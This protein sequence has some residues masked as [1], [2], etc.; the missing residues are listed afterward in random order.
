LVIQKNKWIMTNL[1]T[2]TKNRRSLFLKGALILTF[3][4]ASFLPVKAEQNGME[5]NDSAYYEMPGVNVLMFTNWYNE[6]FSDSKMSG[7][8]IIHHGKR[9]V[10]NGD[11]RLNSTP[12]QWDPIPKFNRKEVDRENNVVKAWLEYPDFEYMIQTEPSGDDIIISVHLDKPIPEKL[13]GMVGFNIEFLP[14]AYFEKTYLMDGKPGLVPHYP[15]GPTKMNESG[16]TE[17]LAIATGHK[18]VLAPEDDTRRIGVESENELMFFDGRNKAQNGW[19]VLRSLIPSGETGR[20]IEW[21]M[22]VSSVDE[23][24]RDPVISFSQVGYHP[25]QTKKAVIELDKNADY[26]SEASLYKLDEN[27]KKVVVHTGNVEQWGFYQRY[28]Y[29]IFDFSD[30][31]ESGIYLVQYGDTESRPLRI[32]E[33]VYDNIWHPTL[34]VFIPVQM[35]HVLVN[36][37][38]RVWHGASHLDDAL[39]APVNHEHFDLYVQG[40]ATDTQYQPG[41]HIP[42]LNVGGW[43]DAGDYDIRTQSQYYTILNLVNAWA[44]FDINRDE[45]LVEQENRYVDLHHPDGKNDILQQIEHGA[46]GLLAQHKAVGHAIPGIIVSDLSQYTH[47]G[48]GLTKTDN[49]I[50]NPALDSLEVDYPYSG[51]F[52]DRWAF[53]SKSTPLNYGSAAALAASSRALKDYAPE[54]AQE[55]LE[56]AIGVWNQEQ[57]KEPDIF[58]VG[59][60]TGGPM[61]LEELRAAT[62]LLIATGNEKYAARIEEMWPNVSEGFVFLASTLLPALD[63]MDDAFVAKVKK[64]TEVYVEELEELQKQNPFGVPI[65]EGG[66]AG[67]GTIIGYG[68]TNYMLHKA[69]PDIMDKENVFKALNYILGCHPDSDISFVSGVGL[70]T[71]KVAYGMNRADFSYIPGGIVPGVLILDPDFP[72]N[73]EDWPF[74]WGENEY[75]ITVGG[76]YIYLANAVQELLKD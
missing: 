24:L 63:Y 56:T 14:S 4:G 26:L 15:S 20:V 2:P 73:K 40:P 75:V 25:S 41:E 62:Q 19:L 49:L 47:L 12:E 74:L 65:T 68:I 8:E 5:L 61:I 50:F 37:A 38:Y 71:K 28:Q 27:G 33:N 54:F 23:W 11:V 6:N 76:S 39:Q 67:N 36:E 7:I 44:D 60:T 48:D 29:G 53:T 30:I 52:D 51:T 69:F 42:G 18:M 66:W 13:E 31:T 64:R 9:T 32:G 58:Y 21:K 34:D 70:H 10:T 55:C 22:S 59:N 1:N 72:E 17:P 43:Y 3:L 16:Q 57:G 35:D 45:T 46:I